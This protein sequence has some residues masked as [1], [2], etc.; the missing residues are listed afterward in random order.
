MVE[1]RRSDGEKADRRRLGLTGGSEGGS[2]EQE[3]GLAQAA[4]LKRLEKTHALFSTLQFCSSTRFV[5]NSLPRV[6]KEKNASNGD[7][8]LAPVLT[9]NNN[10]VVSRRRE[11][12]NQRTA[13][14]EARVFQ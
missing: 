3:P 7:R 4:M 6:R 2:D 8:A 9:N 11:S 12:T 5:Y 1:N 14:E 10:V 13:S